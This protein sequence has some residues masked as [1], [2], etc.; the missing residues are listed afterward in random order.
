MTKVIE[1]KIDCAYIAIKPALIGDKAHEWGGEFV[2]ITKI[3]VLSAADVGRRA[4]ETAYFFHQIARNSSYLPIQ[5][6]DALRA[7]LS[8]REHSWLGLCSV[9]E[10]IFVPLLKKSAG[11]IRRD[12]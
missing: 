12:G 7:T 6:S 8:I 5:H 10:H 3:S 11:I 2:Q 4:R 9:P 1:L